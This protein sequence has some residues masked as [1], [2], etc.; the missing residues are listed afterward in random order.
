MLMNSLLYYKSSLCG[1]GT[2]CP[3][4]MMENSIPTYSVSKKGETYQVVNLSNNNTQSD[5]FGYNQMG[6]YQL[7]SEQAVIGAKT[8][9][10]SIFS[11]A[12]RDFLKINVNDISSI[13]PNR[14][15]FN[16][17]QT[18]E[19]GYI[20]L[21]D[22]YILTFSQYSTDLFYYLFLDKEFNQMNND[23]VPVSTTKNYGYYGYHQIV[24]L[25]GLKLLICT[26][27]S[28]KTSVECLSGSY[29][30]AEFS[31]SRF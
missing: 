5:T 2:S 15:Y 3:L 23:W 29:N 18:Y 28:S 16:V 6:I 12:R 26:L 24:E 27:T 13:D 20:L 31:F 22:E 21:N 11:A 8:S 17:S 1:E 14:D 10:D 25:Y 4:I 7:S 19:L 9:S 30:L